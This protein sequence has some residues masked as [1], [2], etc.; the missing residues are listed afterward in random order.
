MLDTAKRLYQNKT[1][2]APEVYQ[3]S[4]GFPTLLLSGTADSETDKVIT[5]GESWEG[6]KFIPMSTS[7]II[8]HVTIFI[9]KFSKS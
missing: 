1:S 5:P 6:V 9:K 3:L 4:T 7:N 2:E 8:L